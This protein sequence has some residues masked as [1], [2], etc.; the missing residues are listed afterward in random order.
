MGARVVFNCRIL[1]CFEEY[2][3]VFFR[4]SFLDLLV[5]LVIRLGRGRFCK[6]FRFLIF[7]FRFVIFVERRR[8]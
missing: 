3:V 7:N 5:I 8:D 1:D 4:V 6:K 2:N